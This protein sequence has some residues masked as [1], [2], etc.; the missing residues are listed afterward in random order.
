[1]FSKPG[2]EGEAKTS[3]SPLTKELQRSVGCLGEKSFSLC[4]LIQKKEAPGMTGSHLTTK[5]RAGTRMKAA[6]REAG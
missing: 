1:M 2:E 3:A 4:M 5:G 6:R